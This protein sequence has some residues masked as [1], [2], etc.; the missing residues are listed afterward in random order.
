MGALRTLRGRRE[1]PPWPARPRRRA[2]RALG[3]AVG[4]RARLRARAS[5]GGRERDTRCGRAPGVEGGEDWARERCA[6]EEHTAPPSAPPFAPR[7]GPAPSPAARPGRRCRRPPARRRARRPRR[8]WRSPRATPPPRPRPRPRPR[9]PRRRRRQPKR[10]RRTHP[11]L[12]GSRAPPSP[13]SFCTAPTVAP[14]PGRA[15]KVGGGGGGRGGGAWG[16]R[17]R[18]Q[19][20]DPTRPDP[21]SPPPA[22]GTLKL[23]YPSTQQQLLVWKTRPRR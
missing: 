15:C 12:R 18:R 3:P 4:R 21:L 23:A 11:P 14:A 1:R 10:R 16:R 5:D 17:A 7:C 20:S 22:G 9:S 6:S 19:P 2:W 13:R 8:R